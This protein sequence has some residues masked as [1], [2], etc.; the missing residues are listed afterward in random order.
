M[1]LGDVILA[2]TDLGLLPVLTL[3]AVIGLAPEATVE[4]CREAS[5]AGVVQPASA[6]APHSAA[7]RLRLD[8]TGS[9]TATSSTLSS[10][11][12]FWA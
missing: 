4:L 8:S 5:A 9:T 6:L 3:A 10:R 2:L 1:S 11:A 7:T 12:S